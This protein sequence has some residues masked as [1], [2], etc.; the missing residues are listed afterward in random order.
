LSA[1][2]EAFAAIAAVEPA[3]VWSLA[4]AQEA[5]TVANPRIVES[6]A[7]DQRDKMRCM[8]VLYSMPLQDALRSPGLANVAVC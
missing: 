7:A 6:V 1:G 4:L 8:S 5:A 2:L 3:D